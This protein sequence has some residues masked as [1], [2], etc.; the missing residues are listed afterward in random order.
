MT[1]FDAIW[2]AAA[3]AIDAFCYEAWTARPQARADV[4]SRP[5]ADPARPVRAFRAGLTLAPAVAGTGG[6]R[7]S[8]FAAP[9]VAVTRHALSCR[10][11]ALP[12]ALRDGDRVERDATGETFAVVGIDALGAGELTLHITRT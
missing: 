7:A 12:Y 8:P 2:A 11:D 1:E 4:N 5:G 3:P 9:G 6:G 10:V